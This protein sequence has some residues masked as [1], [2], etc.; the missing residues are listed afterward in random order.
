MQPRFSY[1]SKLAIKFLELAGAGL[2]S[3]IA[4]YLF[5]WI[6]TPLA[7]PPPLVQVTPADNEMMRMVRDE[8]ALLVELRRELDDQR[9]FEQVAVVP[10]PLPGPKPSKQ[11]L[12]G[13]LCHQ[14]PERTM[15]IEAKLRTDEPMPIQPAMAVSRSLPITMEPSPKTIE[16]SASAR[17]VSA[18]TNAEGSSL[19]MLKRIGAWFLPGNGDAPRPPMPIGKFLQS[20]M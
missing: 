19:G 5:A 20:A 15:P 10:M 14:T 18:S 17:L 8:Q 4:A 1:L 11:T 6:A 2:A 13:P 7:P 3:T 9:K 16:L 12:A